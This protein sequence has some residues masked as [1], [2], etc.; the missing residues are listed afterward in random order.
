MLLSNVNARIQTVFLA[1]LLLGLGLL[2]ACSKGGEAP[3][4]E[5]TWVVTDHKAPAISAMSQEEADS[6]VGKVAQYTQQKASFDGEVCESPT[7]EKTTMQDEDFLTG[8]RISPESLGFKQGP[9]EVVE[10]YCG[11]KKWVAP[12][13]ILIKIDEDRVFTVWDGVFFLLHKQ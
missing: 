1:S 11:N 10:V 13:S 6:W 2:I 8:F 3:F 7:Y 5:G 9:I 12:G 4:F